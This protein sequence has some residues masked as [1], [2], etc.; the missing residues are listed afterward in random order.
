MPPCSWPRW[1]DRDNQRLLPSN[2]QPYDHNETH[3][4]RERR[5]FMWSAKRQAYTLKKEALGG[6]Q[7]EGKYLETRRTWHWPALSLAPRPNPLTDNF[8]S[9][10]AVRLAFPNYHFPPLLTCLLSTRSIPIVTHLRALLFSLRLGIITF[11]LH[12]VVN[13]GAGWKFCATARRLQ[14]KS[15]RNAQRMNSNVLSGMS[16]L[17]VLDDK[18]FS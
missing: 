18:K 7:S 4:S 5:A 6:S 8:V 1:N 16:R 13:F 9:L 11:S 2:F 12:F 14:A 10:R 3:R 15:R 17:Q